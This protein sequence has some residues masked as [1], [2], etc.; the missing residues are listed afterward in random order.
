MEVKS[1]VVRDRIA[2]GTNS[3]RDFGSPPGP[4]SC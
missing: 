2:L 1:E 4:K 3:R